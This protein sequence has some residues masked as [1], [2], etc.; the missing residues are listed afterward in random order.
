M[1]QN[2]ILVNKP[3]SKFVANEELKDAFNCECLYVSS[4]K[5]Q[6]HWR[7]AWAHGISRTR[8]TVY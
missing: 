3:S 1:E 2:F 8:D 4:C 5:K 6:A 7:G